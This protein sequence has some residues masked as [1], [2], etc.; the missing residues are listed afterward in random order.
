MANSRQKADIGMSMTVLL[1]VT[2]I[3][4]VIL[5]LKKHGVLI[6]PRSV[7][8]MTHW[9]CGFA[10]IVLAFIHWKQFDNMLS[11]MKGKF[12]WF[13]ATTTLLKITLVLTLLTGVVKLFSPVKIPHLGLWHYGLGIAMS[14]L[15]VIHLFCGIPCWNRLRKKSA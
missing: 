2:L 9:I 1:G 15:A 6:E 4:G 10:M 3:T 7:I 8:K 11:A 13:Y 12:K 5:H 14:V